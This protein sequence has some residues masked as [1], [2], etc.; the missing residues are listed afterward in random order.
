MPRLSCWFIRASLVYLALGFTL[1]A[2]LLA[3]EGLDLGPSIRGVLPVHMEMLL[4]GW[5][6]QLALGVAFWILPRFLW[7]APR[8]NETLIWLAFW[9]INLGIGGVIAETLFGVPGLAFAGRMAEV[10]G[11]LAFVIGTWRRVRP[12]AP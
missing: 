5:L 1:G 11:V 4:V 7:G 6:V 8:G 12:F 2:I 3:V 9:L 10:G